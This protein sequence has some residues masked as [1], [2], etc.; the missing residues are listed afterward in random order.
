M[1]LKLTEEQ[2]MIQA[3]AKEFT[4]K[5]I[6]PSCEETDRLDKFPVEVAR[7]LAKNE[8]LTMRAPRKYGGSESSYV[9]IVIIN[10]QIGYASYPLGCLVEATNS[11]IDSIMHWGSEE[12]QKKFI[13]PLCNGDWF[14]SWAFTEPETGSNP[15]MVQTKAT[16]DG[17][18]YILNGQKRFISFSSQTGTIVT[19]AKDET[20]KL[21]SFVFEKNVP[22]YSTQA[23]EKMGARGT[24]TC[25]VYIDNVRIPKS[26][27]LGQKGNGFQQF[28]AVVPGAKVQL[29]AAAT[30]MGQAAIDESIRYARERKAGK[31]QPIADMMSIQWLLA[32]METRVW[33][34]RWLSYW[35]ASLQDEGKDILKEGSG[36]KLYASQTIVDV[37]RMGLQVH[38]AYGSTKAFKI[39]RLYRDAKMME[40]M[41]GVN[42]IN[43]T[44]VASCMLA[45]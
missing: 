30:G 13:P 4:V 36:A 19:Y 6:E 27:V 31:G 33:A 29:A 42:E 18:H 38:G 15:R 34:V 25:E 41:M 2:K 14:A 8:L 1:D 22:G 39:E 12:I 20:G 3:A 7:K 26:Y 40:I 9:D 10:E 43:R 45:Q 32:E 5:E 17:E 11:C 37:V 23:I 21:S 35:S 28:L 44:V 16:P 24:D